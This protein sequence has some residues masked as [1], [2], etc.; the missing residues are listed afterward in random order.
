MRI[1]S[2]VPSATE[3]IARLG[4]ALVSGTRRP[5]DTANPGR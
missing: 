1:V 5:R 3:I 2:L 4:L